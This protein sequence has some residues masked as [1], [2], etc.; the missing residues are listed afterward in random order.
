[1][2]NELNKT[3]E[4]NLALIMPDNMDPTNDNKY[5]NYFKN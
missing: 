3:K 5:F 2:N 4:T 1:M